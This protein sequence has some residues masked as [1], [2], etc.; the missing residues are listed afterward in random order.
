MKASTFAIA[1]SASLALAGSA[2]AAAGETPLGNCYNKVITSCNGT[3]HPGSCA[4]AAM[5]ACDEE[6]GHSV[7][8]SKLGLSAA[9]PVRKSLL[10]PAVQAAR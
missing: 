9:K 3:A 8:G 6:F 2:Y 1:L 10:L 7:G 5:D 4:D